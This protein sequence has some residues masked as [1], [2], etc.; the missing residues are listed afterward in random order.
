MIGALGVGI[1][2]RQAVQGISRSFL[3]SLDLRHTSAALR[4]VVVLLGTVGFTTQGGMFGAAGALVLRA[5]WRR[6]PG[7]AGGTR[8]VLKLLAQQPYG[9]TFLGLAAAGLL[10]YAA[11][12][13]VEAS[14]RR[15]PSE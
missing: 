4:S 6:D 10:A 5:A 11:Y 2:I 9:L 1:G 15:F 8:D 13:L 12:A 7:E 14:T 3:G